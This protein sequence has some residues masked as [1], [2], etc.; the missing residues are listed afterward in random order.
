MAS[1]SNSDTFN[2]KRQNT[3]IDNNVTKLTYLLD[4]VFRGQARNVYIEGM[5]TVQF[6]RNSM[7]VEQPE[8]V[9]QLNRQLL[10][11]YNMVITTSNTK[12][13]ISG[14]LWIIRLIIIIIII[15]IIILF[16]WLSCR[17]RT[18]VQA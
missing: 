16:T 8:I 13:L 2:A 9:C 1:A 18:Y 12:A 10:I 11:Q 17:Q 4:N 6:M 15:I 3:N 7:S 14:T 5:S